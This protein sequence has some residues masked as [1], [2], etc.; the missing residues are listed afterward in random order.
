MA[1][2]GWVWY[3]ARRESR[4]ISRRVLVVGLGAILAL[5]VRG[6]FMVA[7]SSLPPAGIVLIHLF[8]LGFLVRLLRNYLALPTLESR[9]LLEYG[10]EF[11]SLSEQQREKLQRLHSC[12]ALMGRVPWDERDIEL[13]MRADAAA[14]RLLMPGFVVLLAGFW[15]ACWWDCI[16][17]GGANLGKTAICFTWLVFVVLALPTVVRLWTQ[18]DEV[19]EPAVVEREAKQWR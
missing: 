16:P 7:G 15:A 9:A 12:D 13:Q 14:Y 2:W 6:E 5:D 11:E 3:L 18:P 8:V 1:Q 19:G 4:R 17:I 10:L